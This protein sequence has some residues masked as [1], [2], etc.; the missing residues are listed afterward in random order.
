MKI[1]S[2]VGA[3]PQFIKLAPI[4]RAL[5][6]HGD[7]VSHQIIH[8]GQH[9][10]EN[11]SGLFFKEL[12]I[13]NPEYNLHVGSGT[14]AEQT[15]KA[16]QGLETI[17][18]DQKPDHIIVYGDTNATLSGAL[19]ATY[20]GIPVSH[21]EAGLRSY[22]HLMPEEMNR[23]ITDRLSTYLFCPDVHSVTNLRSEGITEG[24]YQVGD[25][26]VDQLLHIQNTMQVRQPQLPFIFM[27]LHRQETSQA[28]DQIHSILLA[29]NAISNEVPIIFPAHPRIKK[30][31]DAS[32]IKFGKQFHIVEPLGY[33]DTI[34][35]IQQAQCVITDS[36][37]MQKEAYILKT[38]C[39]T[40]R[41]ETEWT[42]TLTDGWNTLVAFD[43][44]L[45]QEKFKQA[46]NFNRNLKQHPFYGNGEAAKCIIQK[47]IN[48]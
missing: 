12:N 14:H 6:D 10:D 22:N 15:G 13:P 3:R 36:G 17:F 37:G 32:D 26:M 5:L 46:L 1:F 41:T 40:L 43:V 47:I 24:V 7:E 20:L 44:T 48:P 18:K 19:A 34:N 16:L 4:H 9:Y 21:I 38:P 33:T 35:H 29:L 8:T 2:I 23:I 27:T 11:M 28:F 30:Y 39:V 42:D 45:F 31:F 25:V